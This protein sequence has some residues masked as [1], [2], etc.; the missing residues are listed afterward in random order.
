MRQLVEFVNTEN[1]PCAN[2]D[3]RD[4]T[5]MFFCT[6]CGQ[7][8]CTHCREHTHRAKMFSSHDVVHMSKCNKDTQRRCP[9]HGEQYIMFSQS[10]KQ[11]LCAICFRETPSDA[12]LHC[13]DI[14][15]AWQLVS[16]KMERAIT[17][18]CELQTNV[19]DGLLDLKSQVD[20]LKCGL[21]EE[22][23]ILNV[24]YQS[25]QETMS[26]TYSVILAELQREF[27]TKDRIIKTN[28]LALG[29]A[30]PVLQMHVGLCTAFTSAAGKHQF[31]E[32]A[33]PM[34]ERLSRV[35]QLGHIPRS[36]F[37]TNNFKVHYKSEFLRAL[38]PLMNIPVQPQTA[39]DAFYDQHY[40]QRYLDIQS[41]QH[42]KTNQRAPTQIKGLLE[43]GRFNS[44]CRTFD[45]QLQ[46]LNN[47]LKTVKERLGELHKDVA[48]LRRVNTPPLIIRYEN[49]TRDFRL[50]EQ[51]LEHQQ[52][53]MER[54]KAVFDALWEEQL[55]RIHLEKEVFHSQMNDILS[56]KGELKQLQLFAQQ[57]EPFI[58]SFTSGINTGEAN[59]SA[60]DVTNHQHLQVLLDHLARLQIQEPIHSSPTKECRL[61]QPQQPN[62]QIRNSHTVIDNSSYNRETKDMTDECGTSSCGGVQTVL[63]SSGNILVYGTKSES[64]KGVL[65]QL[66]EKA[67]MK[68]DRK[69]SFGYDESYERN[70][71]RCSRK[72]P[73]NQLKLKNV[74]GCNST[75]KVRSLYRSLKGGNVDM[76]STEFAFEQHQQ[77]GEESEYQKISETSSIGES[78]KQVQAQI[79][80]IPNETELT[81][82]KIKSVRPSKSQKVYPASDSEEL[83][84]GIQKSS[85]TVDERSRRRASCDSLSTTGSGSR[86][87]SIIDTT[88]TTVG[89]K[90]LTV[91]PKD[92]RKTL[93]LFIGPP[94][95]TPLVQKQR[96][97]E[98]F[99]RPKNKRTIS[100]GE[101]TDS[102]GLGQ[103]KK[104][105]SFEGHEEAV[106][107]LVAA[108]QETRSQMR[109]T[110]LN[111]HRIHRK[112]KTN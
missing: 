91:S 25:V 8:L 77:Q 73:E 45:N 30:L 24:Y 13:M 63:D 9:N 65:S 18:I 51:Q 21:E 26:Q 84:Y 75:N 48:L 76:T 11:M 83:F 89:S 3:K 79:H 28:L 37:I 40:Q 42:N 86:R 109:Q 87:S 72:S 95:N 94:N 7:A 15:T 105:D 56:L 1:P 78:K 46:E 16:K 54:L 69:K 52:K 4:K 22:K 58:K 81:F 19:H 59:T 62:S 61:Q 38:Q 88:T 71:N 64:K 36:S 55:C 43:S 57:L 90:R 20:D 68:E 60:S 108:V 100:M 6:T 10:T 31:L 66:I 98:T 97:W 17:S 99:P 35:A 70:Q 92:T 67:K 112:S 41:L 101:V 53:E 85:D 39:K 74:Q 106:R 93:V 27:D 49:I 111:Q 32:L 34:L 102:L 5:A 29:S 33:Y 82:T 96:S 80:R 50:L 2:C 47:Q 103:L 44:H 104:A 23:R 14:E 107:T 110:H 12:R